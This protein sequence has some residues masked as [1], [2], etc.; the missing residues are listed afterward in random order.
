MGLSSLF[1]TEKHNND[2]HTYRCLGKFLCS[3]LPHNKTSRIQSLSL[4]LTFVFI[5]LAIVVFW[6]RNRKIKSF[7]LTSAFMVWIW[8]TKQGATPNC[9][10]LKSKIE[11][12][13]TEMQKPFLV[14]VMDLLQIM[15]VHIKCCVKIRHKDVT[16]EKN[17]CGIFWHPMFCLVI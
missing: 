1:N 4:N 15:N 16:Y 3:Y 7:S 5:Q 10:I 17:P 2:Q 13:R 8:L 12:K 11:L 6:K 14:L 9:F